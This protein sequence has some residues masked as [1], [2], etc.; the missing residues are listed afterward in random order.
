VGAGPQPDYDFYP[1]P[2]PDGSP[3]PR[4]RR[5]PELST[6]SPDVDPFVPGGRLSAPPPRIPPVFGRPSPPD[7]PHAQAAVTAASGPATVPQQ[8]AESPARPGAA[9]STPAARPVPAFTAHASTVHT[10]VDAEASGPAAALRLRGPDVPVGDVRLGRRARRRP[11]RLAVVATGLFTL[12]LAGTGAAV[13]L[14]PRFLAHQDETQ[15]ASTR[16]ELP[17]EAAGLPRVTGAASAAQAKAARSRLLSAGAS[18]LITE[19]GVYGARTGPRAVV[20]AARPQEP[21][22]APERELVRAGFA[23]AV[24]KSDVV[25]TERDPGPLGGWFGCG[26]HQG[27]TTMCLA[28][29]AGAVL[30]ITVTTTG[31]GAVQTARDVRAAVETRAP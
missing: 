15:W 4:A 5:V 14:T 11:G 26:V 3:V 13:A 2:P 21:L 8:R 7:D 30:S 1:Q 29:D 18:R 20:V 17:R 24:A 16:V 22:T 9:E 12:L 10:P 6:L 27:R 19:L 31:P 28:V 25:V 23:A